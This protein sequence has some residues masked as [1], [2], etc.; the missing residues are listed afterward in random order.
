MNGTRRMEFVGTPER[1]EWIV[2]DQEWRTA[3]ETETALQGSPLARRDQCAFLVTKLCLVT[4]LLE[5]LLPLMNYE[6]ELREG[7][8]PS[9][10]WEQGTAHRGARIVK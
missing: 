2:I 3:H 6:A 8:F 5:A 7:L 1:R 10:A 4:R 9:G